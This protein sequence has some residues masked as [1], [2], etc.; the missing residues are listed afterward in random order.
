MP[1]FR[2]KSVKI[3][4]GQKKFTRTL[5]ARPWQIWGMVRRSS[6]LSTGTTSGSWADLQEGQSITIGWQS[7]WLFLCHAVVNLFDNN[8]KVFGPFDVFQH[9][10]YPDQDHNHVGTQ[11]GQRGTRKPP[12]LAEW[13]F[14]LSLLS[15]IFV[16]VLN[17][18][19]LISV[20][21]SIVNVI[22]MYCNVL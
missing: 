18:V 2:V 4:T 22:F 20:V 13:S 1:I 17:K 15:G 11:A 6:L 12:F 8:W 9:H 21:I 10:L 5:S 3:Y 7:F 19:I 14:D 16:A